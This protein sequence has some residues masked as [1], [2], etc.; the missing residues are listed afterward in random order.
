MGSSDPWATE[1]LELRKLIGETRTN[2]VLLRDKSVGPL[3]AM[4]NYYTDKGHIIPGNRLKDAIVTLQAEMTELKASV[5]SGQ[6]QGFGI[7][8]GQNSGFGFQVQQGAGGSSLHTLEARI[9]AADKKSSALEVE[10]MIL[11]QSQS[12]PSG[13][14]TGGAPFGTED[15][16]GRGGKLPPNFVDD[17]RNMDV[18]LDQL[19][20][21]SDGNSITIGV[22]TF[23]S[24]RDCETFIRQECPGGSLNTF[25]YDMVS[26]L[27]RVTRRG[28]KTSPTDEVAYEAAVWKGGFPN[29]ASQM[30][31]SSYQTAFPGPL[32]VAATAEQSAV[33]PI[34]AIKTCAAWEG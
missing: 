4:Y 28:M 9:I 29:R 17:I 20:A 8:G 23:R 19:E 13:G 2:L 22:R 18:R 33:Q 32:S 34:P 3:V 10:L 12:T 11:K 24:S 1:T 15:A 5:G 30:I 14:A 26:L 16:S 21:K 25:C 31:H 27:N 7:H 6:Q